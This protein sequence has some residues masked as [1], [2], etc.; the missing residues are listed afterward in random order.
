[1]GGVRVLPTRKPVVRLLVIVLLIV[2]LGLSS[3]ERGGRG[4]GRVNAS[5]AAILIVDHGFAKNITYAQNNGNVIPLNKTSS[6]T[7]NDQEVYSYLVA[8]F[9]AVNFT[10]QWYN[11]DGQLYYNRTQEA[12]CTATPCTVTSNLNIGSYSPANTMFGS[13][14]LTV[15]ANGNQLYSASFTLTPIIIEN[16]HWSLE[17]LQSEPPRIHANLTV[18]IHPTNQSWTSYPLYL[19]NAANV[20]AYDTTTHNSLQV[21]TQEDSDQNEYYVVDF[22]GPRGNGY[23]FV[24]NFDLT[25]GLNALSG[26]YGGQFALTWYESLYQRYEQYGNP[27]PETFN[28]TLPKGAKFIDVVST[29]IVPLAQT[30]TNQTSITFNSTY[31][32]RPIQWT[33][34]YQDPTYLNAHPNTQVPPFSQAVQI[35]I[36][37]LPLTLGNVNL[38]AAVMSVF[39]LT[40]SEVL[41]PLSTRSGFTILIN[42]KPIRIAALLL[43]ALFLVTTGYQLSATVPR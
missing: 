29:N 14:T 5:Q 4:I 16:D 21:I 22:S 6:F 18:T 19:P 34:I 24:L 7:Q 33:I 37:Y 41:S 8:S 17:I 30:V 38:W 9:Y 23:S 28:I 2:L 43:V 15:L 25:T 26:W 11:P 42:R 3:G 31:S 10:W 1:M 20:T 40:A 13:W 12:Q 35:I 32:N 36:P 27:V 39:L